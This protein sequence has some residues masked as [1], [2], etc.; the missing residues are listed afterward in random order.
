MMWI[1]SKDFMMGASNADPDASPDEKPAHLVHIDGFWLD[2]TPVTNRQFKEFVE[3]TEYK[4]TAEQ[5]PTL[6]EIMK[7]IPPGTPPPDATM[8]VPGSL[9]F[10][11]TK[12]PVA[13]NSPANWWV[14]TPHANWCHPTGPRSSIDGK[15]DHPVVHVSWFD[16]STYA[17]WA[18]KRLPT[19][20]EWECAARGGNKKA[21]Y[22]WGPAEF[23]HKKPQTNIWQGTFPYKSIKPKGYWGTTPVK[24]YPPN[25]YGLYCMGGN[26][27]QWCSDYYH[28]DY[29]AKQARKKVSINPQGAETSFDPIEPHAI[30]RIHKGGSFLCSDQYCKGY[31]IT[32]RM[33]TSP[34]TSLQ[35]LGF[36]CAKS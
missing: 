7:Q 1:P 34:D 33:R 36:R 3:K 23:N 29:Y 20:A 25:K 19:E 26:V 32:A 28:R 31:R 11:P 9:V 8:L 13:L 2:E 15:E 24:K 17:Q 14:W 16:A 6:E 10:K 5:A 4:T 35:H 21:R 30:K 27:W 22:S 18:G 12:G